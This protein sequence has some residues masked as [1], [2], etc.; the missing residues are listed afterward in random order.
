MSGRL[1]L[2]R[3]FTWAIHIYKGIYFYTKLKVKQYFMQSRPDFRIIRI[4]KE[5]SRSQVGWNTLSNLVGKLWSS[6]LSLLS[7]PIFLAFLGPE[8]YGLVGLY[9]SFEV[10]FNFL[11]FGLSATINREI[12]RN[13]AINKSGQDS[14]N[15]LRTFEYFY[16]AIGFAV[17]IL[18][19]SFAGWMARNWVVIH[20]LT[21]QQVQVSIYMMA[22]MFAA[23]WPMTLYAGAFRGLQKQF[24]LNF[25]TIMAATLRVVVAIVL[26]RYISSQVTI[27]MSWQAI[28]C[29]IEIIFLLFFAWKELEKTSKDKPHIDLMIIKRVWKFALSFNMVGVLGMILSQAGILIG[30][31]FVNLSELGYY[32]V[33]A[34]AAGSLTLIAYSV[35]TAIFPRFAADTERKDNQALSNGFHRTTNIINYSSFGFSFLLILFP[36]NIL[37]WW[38]RNWNTVNH[39]SLILLFLGSAGLFNSLSNPSYSLLVASGKIKVPLLCNIVNFIIFIPAL[40]ILIPN[41][42]ILPAAVVWFLENVI[43]YF[44]YTISVGKLLLNE[45]FLKHLKEISP[46]FA[47]SLLWFLGGKIL[48]IFIDNELLKLMI[49]IASAI[50]YFLSMAPRIM[51]DITFKNTEVVC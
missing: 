45:T 16:W 43:T 33:A 6:L 41:F 39:T 10:I 37:Y 47:A 40:F 9:A 22:L 4:L 29:G 7:V 17:A 42:G 13:L 51:K 14:K 1:Y 44:V 24:L 20:D 5:I 11:D 28:S 25:I 18:I 31:K 49:I 23:R 12:A 15:L 32:S 35:G 2:K 3:S 46:Y 8:A 50:G 36:T 19:A 21:P 48:C 34:T 26:L 38:T 27:F 30:S